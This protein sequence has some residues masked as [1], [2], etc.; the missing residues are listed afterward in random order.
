MPFPLTIGSVL[1]SSLVAADGD[2]FISSSLSLHV[3]AA[4][5]PH[6]PT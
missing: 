5:P 3:N 1:M 4:P 2:T 6:V